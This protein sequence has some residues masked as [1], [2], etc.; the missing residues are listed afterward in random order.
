MRRRAKYDMGRSRSSE[1]SA[2]RTAKRPYRCVAPVLK[3][4][5]LPAPTV[6][7]FVAVTPSRSM[8]LID[9]AMLP[10]NGGIALLR[11]KEMPLPALNA[12]L[13]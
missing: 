11:A 6:T 9:K 7:G 8:T 13:A 4:I 2:L 12:R 10:L 1:P 5:P 3:A